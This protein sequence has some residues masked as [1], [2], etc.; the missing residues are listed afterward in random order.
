MAS[1]IESTWVHAAVFIESINGSTGT[2]FL[3]GKPV[4]DDQWKVFLVTNKHVLHNEPSVRASMVS[5]RL[6]VNVERGAGLA[7]EAVDYP[8]RVTG[9][10][11]VREH[12]DPSVDVLA[13]AV[14]P[15]FKC[16]DGLAN[17]F[18]SMDMFA[19]SDRRAELDITAGEEIVTVGYPSGI[20]QGRTNFPLIR[21]GIIATR[22]GEE[23]HEEQTDAN[24]ER[25][26][27]ITRGFLIDGATI[28]GSSGSP[29][30]LKPVTGRN[31]KNN[32]MYGSCPPLLLGIVAETRFAPIRLSENTVIP[33]FAG[34]GLAFDVETIIET[35]AL[36]N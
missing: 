15:L 12:Q 32:I 34:L 29:V 14:S 5:V 18:V 11:W 26:V 10:S 16:V 7:A 31:Q 35:I 4:G 23:L 28:P 30:I 6:H 3:V 19:T 25:N 1:P 8:L 9:E 27:R 24:G 13:I 33:S 22:L 21:Q 17:K 2:G 36:F 20:R